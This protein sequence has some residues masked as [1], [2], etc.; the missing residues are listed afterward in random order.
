[1]ETTAYD[2]GVTRVLL[3]ED[4]L[5]IAEP[6]ARALDREGY[7]VNHC[8]TGQEAID[9]APEAD[10]VVLDLGLPDIDGLDV[11]RA[12]RN[13]GLTI[14]VLILT[15]RAEE[16]DLVVG[17]DAGADEYVTKPFRLVAFLSLLCGLLRHA[18]GERHYEDAL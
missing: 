2:R 9:A 1:M 15:A 13:Q 8:A 12:I 4:D 10:F 6:L 18:G 5:A 16:V 11:C 7:E 17:L 14:P 3:A